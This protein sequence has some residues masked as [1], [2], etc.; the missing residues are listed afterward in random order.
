MN[1]KIPMIN[2]YSQ[3]KIVWF[4]DKMESFLSGKIEAPIY[5][6]IKPT[7]RCMHRCY[8]CIYEPGFSGMHETFKKA[9]QLPK[10]KLIEI[11][12]DLKQIGTKA[13]TFSGGGE[14]LFH[15][16]IVEILN[17]VNR[18]GLDNS[19]I[20]NGQLL[21]GDKA[22]A[23]ENAKWV[24]ISMDYYDAPSFEKSRRAPMKSVFEI[25]KNIKDFAKIKNKNC[26]LT[27]NFIVTNDNY[28]H[29]FE[30][31]KTLKELGI[32]NIRFAP[33][34]VSDFKSYHDRLKDKVLPQIEQ[35]RE[36]LNDEN[37]TVYDS[38]NIDFQAQK[39]PLNRCYMMQILPVIGADGNVYSCHNKAYDKYGLIGSIKNQKFSQM[40][41]SPET[42]S[43]FENLN[44]VR[45]CSDHQCAADAKNILINELLQAKDDNF[46]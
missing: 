38:Y 20:T 17:E 40:W 30:V 12:N 43:V 7:N 9:E 3:Y 29:L 28:T 10:E 23:L 46:I 21:S 11:V 44:P 34:W 36:V 22:M 4:K 18:I 14:P 41:F 32:E 27:V 35:A 37:F 24:R 15:P 31:A 1:F 6:R 42:K 19:I 5:V 33:I 26:D 8:F 16:D 2:K 13:V 45:H 25:Y 39:R